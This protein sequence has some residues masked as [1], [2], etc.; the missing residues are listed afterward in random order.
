MSVEWLYTLALGFAI[1]WLGRPYRYSILA[2]LGLVLVGLFLLGEEGVFALALFFAL[3]PE[4]AVGL[5]L[6]GAAITF[7][8]NYV[9]WWL[10]RRLGNHGEW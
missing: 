9:G 5:T 4:L 10:G 2:Y 7:T 8:F 3:S 6:L 1:G